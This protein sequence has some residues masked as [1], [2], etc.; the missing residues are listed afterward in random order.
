VPRE[1]LDPPYDLRKQAL[2]QLA[3][4]QLKN[5]VSSMLNEAPPGLE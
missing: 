3:F 1:P 2:S 5:E 4:G